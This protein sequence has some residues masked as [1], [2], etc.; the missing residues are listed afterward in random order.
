[1]K[2]LLFLQQ[3]RGGVER[4]L[5]EIVEERQR[6]K[7]SLLAAGRG[8][9]TTVGRAQSLVPRL[10]VGP[11]RQQEKPNTTTKI[12]EKSQK[13]PSAKGGQVHGQK[14]TSLDVSGTVCRKGWR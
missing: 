6:G 4:M 14:E 11:S 8:R 10:R 7:M 3:K 12:H 1:M 5:E 13:N 2:C 9:W